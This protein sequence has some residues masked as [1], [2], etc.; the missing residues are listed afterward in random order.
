MKLIIAGAVIIL[1][2]IGLFSLR[3]RD[4]A[5]HRNVRPVV[6]RILRLILVVLLLAA[7]VYIFFSVR[8]EGVGALIANRGNSDTVGTSESEGTEVEIVITTDGITVG[9]LRFSSLSEAAE[10][11]RRIVLEGKELIMV[12]DYAD[13]GLYIA[14]RDYLRELGVA[15][16]DIKERTEP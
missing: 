1:A 5:F 2:V 3:T 6:T 16:E 4:T 12:D 14:V 9:K 15:K 11:L 8:K 7:A 13:A 10:T